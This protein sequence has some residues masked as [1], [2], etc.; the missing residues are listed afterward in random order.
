[1]SKIRDYCPVLI[2]HII[3]LDL[4]ISFLLNVPTDPGFHLKPCFSSLRVTESS[5]QLSGN[6]SK[7]FCVEGK[8][9]PTSQ[10][11]IYT[12]NRSQNSPEEAAI[13]SL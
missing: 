12:T 8:D 11:S 3:N 2:L 10:L 5:V 4:F 6:I 7:A 9:K 13:F 1:M